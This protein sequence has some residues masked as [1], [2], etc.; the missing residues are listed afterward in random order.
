MCGSCAI[1]FHHFS[2][3][4]LWIFWGISR[5]RS[6]SSL[7][8]GATR[9]HG[10]PPTGWM[11]I[12]AECGRQRKQAQCEVLCQEHHCG[13]PEVWWWFRRC[14]FCSCWKRTKV[15]QLTSF[16]RCIDVETEDIIKVWKALHFFNLLQ[17]EDVIGRVARHLVVLKRPGSG[18][19]SMPKLEK[20]V[21]RWGTRSIKRNQM[22]GESSTKALDTRLYPN[23]L[24][25]K[26]LQRLY[27]SRNL[28]LVKH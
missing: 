1:Y 4:H 16:H 21:Q 6:C 25:T 11:I 7:F 15:I 17:A 3:W 13:S 24:D 23:H 2:P 19:M 12:F 5:Y 26:A 9:C 27:C 14:W 20:A 22:V 18:K 28:R 8:V 10:R